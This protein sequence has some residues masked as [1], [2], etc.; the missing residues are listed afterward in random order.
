LLAFVKQLQYFCENDDY[1][2][3]YYVVAENIEKFLLMFGCLF[4]TSGEI[5]PNSQNRKYQ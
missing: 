3:S 4:L 5:I 1:E 2:E